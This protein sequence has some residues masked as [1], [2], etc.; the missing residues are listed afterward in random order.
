MIHLH[1]DRIHII[2]DGDLDGVSS[3]LILEAGLEASN[4]CDTTIHFTRPKQLADTIQTIDP[5]LF[6]VLFF[7]DLCPAST[8]PLKGLEDKEIIIIDHHRTSEQIN[9]QSGM[10]PGEL[11]SK[12][13]DYSGK[14][15]A[16]SLVYQWLIDMDVVAEE[17]FEF[18]YK[19]LG[20]LARDWD[21]W[22]HFVPES[23]I[24]AYAA[25]VLGAR[26]M[27][28]E[29]KRYTDGQYTDEFLYP[30]INRVIYSIYTAA[31]QQIA[32]SSKMAERY[33]KHYYLKWDNTFHPVIVSVCYGYASQVSEVF[34][35]RP[36]AIILLY[37]LQH[38]HFSLRTNASEV[39]LDTIAK[40]LGG[41]GHPKA[42]GFDISD[43]APMLSNGLVSSIWNG[44]T[45]RLYQETATI[46]TSTSTQ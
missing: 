18:P 36:D 34:K 17:Q 10:K 42:A 39:E 31:A 30:W 13:I 20:A 26:D 43:L 32:E 44:F 2:A 15:S 22:L 41:G 8:E 12:F 7:V 35:N 40:Q 5:N 46:P 19:H 4:Y 24:L 29:L 3:A 28:Q 6:D 27:Y 45:D 11:W 21:L 16:A 1:G 23:R 9:I 14:H 38:D 25:D 33:Q 37:D